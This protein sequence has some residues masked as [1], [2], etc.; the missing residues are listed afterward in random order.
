[1]KT[2][3]FFSFAL[4]II[5][6]DSNQN[7]IENSLK[8]YFNE[9][10][11]DPSS[12]EP[13]ETNIIDTLIYSEIAKNKISNLEE[14]IKEYDKEIIEIEEEIEKSEFESLKNISEERLKNRI[15]SKELM[16]SDINKLQ[17]YLN[18]DSVLAYIVQ[19]KY[20]AKNGFGAI[21]LSNGYFA[22]NTK[23]EILYY[24]RNLG[25]LIS[26]VEVLMK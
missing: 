24:D 4:I 23:N 11:N 8:K 26:K 10:A 18:N 15:D 13:L 16:S 19:H 5:S 7:K 12:Y 17:P 6:C 1:M 2:I 22:I 25:D 21:T 20:R 3:L 9:N 14:D